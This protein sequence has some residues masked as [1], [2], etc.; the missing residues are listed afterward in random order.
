MKKNLLKILNKVWH[1]ALLIIMG[2]IAFFPFLGSV[3]LFD[4]DEINFAEAARE[5]LVTGNYSDVQINF[6]PFYEKPPLFFWLQA[7]SMKIWGVTEFAARFPN[8]LFGMITLLT[9]YL[10]GKN[11][12]NSRFGLLWALMH[13]S[14]LLAHFYFKTGL[15]DPVFNYFIFLGFYC[16]TRLI[17]STSVHARW[18][19]LLGGSSLGLAVLTKG[20]VGILLPALALLI[21]WLRVG[22][23]PIIH[24][25]ILVLFGLMSVLI[26]CCWFGY[27]TYKDGGAFIR[28][29]IQYHLELFNQP[30]EGHAQPF[31]YHFVVIFFGCFPA[32]ILALGTFG[33]S[34]FEE[35]LQLFPMMQL[36]FWV[37]MIVFSLATTKIVNYSSLAY[38][39]VSFLAAHYLYRIDQKLAIPSRAIHLGLVAVGIFIAVFL[40]VLSILALNKERLYS[41]ISD[42]FTLANIALP[43][44][45]TYLDCLP[46]LSYFLL[47]IVAYY[48]FQRRA[49]IQFVTWSSIAT[50]VCLMLGV[51]LIVPKIEAH[52]Q[53]P[54]IEFYKSL[55]GK[56][57]YVIT[58]GFKSYAPLFYFRQPKEHAVATKDIQWL[59]TGELDKPAYYV[60]KVND[61]AKIS[62][63]PDITL[64]RVEGGF[65]FCRRGRGY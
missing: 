23:K 14:A 28:A 11:Y 44:P 37:V 7:L 38:F 33:R 61:K 3:H 35:P 16:L 21:Y 12:K 26:P 63:Y 8:A 2:S 51:K 53:K 64:S 59:L 48:F 40:I 54:V 39:S 18:W 62:V 17:H 42:E 5:M 46:G 1:C 27:Q 52:I 20:P 57:V 22:C 13:V 24:W 25:Q 49:I 10:V 9:I 50:T 41:F 60:L 43:V 36:L 58:I 30:V 31:Y 4:W 55:E 19:A 47:S 45:W 56:P 32:S 65:I 34:K 6:E 15:I 29:F